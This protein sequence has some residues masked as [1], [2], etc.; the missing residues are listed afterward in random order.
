VEEKEIEVEKEDRS[1]KRSIKK[2]EQ[3]DL[4]VNIDSL[5]LSILSVVKMSNMEDVLN[6]FP[7]RC[8]LI[9]IYF[10]L[11]SYSLISLIKSNKYFYNI[12]Y[13][14]YKLVIQNMRWEL[15]NPKTLNNKDIPYV[16]CLKLINIISNN[17]YLKNNKSLLKIINTLKWR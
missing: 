5:F 10:N 16:Y 6:I 4:I 15:C 7:Y 13:L 11:D 12:R 2:I 14:L 1:G 8:Q 17:K 9:L 3:T